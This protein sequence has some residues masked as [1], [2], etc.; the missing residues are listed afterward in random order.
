LAWTDNSLSE[1]N[2]TIERADDPLFTTNVVKFSVAPNT[3]MFNDTSILRGYYYRV[4][5]DNLVGDSYY[6][7]PPPI[8]GFPTILMRSNY[9]NIVGPAESKIEIYSIAQGA[10]PGSP[11]IMKWLFTP[12]GGQ[13]GFVIQRA[14]NPVFTQNVAEVLVGGNVLTYTDTAAT[15]GTMYYYRVM[16][17]NGM[18]VGVWSNIVVITPH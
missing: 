8:V 13:T 10:A 14:T 4:S 11:I 9:T 17:I 16:A 12:S 2:F 18:G 5:A 3:V 1:T 6:Y 7:G 15:P